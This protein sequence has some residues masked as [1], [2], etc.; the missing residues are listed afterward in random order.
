PEI[1]I[2]SG[3]G[4]GGH[5]PTG[6]EVAIMDY[7]HDEKGVK[8]ITPTR[9]F[10]EKLEKHKDRMPVW[11]DELYYE[12]HRGTLSTQH[13]VKYMNRFFE[14]KT[15]AV[16]ALVSM[17]LLAKDKSKLETWK[18]R[19]E[20]IWKFTLLNQFHDV[21]PGSSIPEVYDDVYDIWEYSLEMLKH[22]E[23]EAWNMI[24][25]QELRDQ[26][27]EK[28]AI[29]IFNGSGAEG[30][31]AIIEVPLLENK[32]PKALKIDQQL[33]PVQIIE[34]DKIE[35]DEMFVKRPKRMLFQVDVAPHSFKILK[36]IH[37]DSLEIG[38]DKNA[39]KTND[40]RE[41]ITIE[42]NLYSVKVDK[43]TGNITS[44]IFKKI[45]K[46][47]LKEPG[48]ELNLFFDWML[49]EPCWN[50]LPSYREL[51]LDI[52]PPNSVKIVEN[53]P[54]RTT[55]EIERI[56][57]NE[58]S[59]AEINKESK[60]IQR[61]SIFSD[62]PGIQVEFLIEWHTC[63]ATLKLDIHTNTNADEVI[64]EVP[65][66][67]STRSTN[68]Q[69][70]HDKPR[71]E[72]YHHTWVDMP[73]SDNSWGIAIVN[74][75]KYGY[76]AKNGRIGLTLIRG[77]KYPYPSGEAWVLSERSRHTLKTG[78]KVPSHADQG[79]HL[80][81]YMLVPHENQWNKSAPFIPHLAHWFNHSI[82]TRYLDDASTNAP[83]NIFQLTNERAEI[84]T[85]KPHEENEGIIIRIVE[86]MNEMSETSVIISPDI[87][88][89]NIIET[90][91][92]ELPLENQEIS[93]EKQGENIT[94]L[95]IQLKP[96]EIKT[97]LLKF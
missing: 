57:K 39:I 96:H 2:F 82:I 47:L 88:I 73:A 79:N 55:V 68:P 80:I 83:D 91:L 48:I 14:W 94:K 69:A 4:D 18:E 90:D 15:A 10:K 8:W 24:T 3:K 31:P 87:K 30:K 67:T 29:I 65:Y 54:V 75:G 53:G 61:I 64:A 42:N 46:E 62:A 50:I 16:E 41:A 60:L 45:N 56:I 32:I 63:D 36:M 77:P 9:Y 70:N 51:K 6:E 44:I 20:N 35:L 11:N 93:V 21:L 26:Q 92:V 27:G 17:V 97:F 34:E 85:V 49:T 74:E 23:N 33:I 81:K 95:N 13:L 5:G 52:P 40:A 38:N 7:L 19:L 66:G 37:E 72:N 89:K 1:A 43:T 71:W 86:I 28:E 58:E 59:E 78:E 22:V 84:T 25:N 12:F 76:D